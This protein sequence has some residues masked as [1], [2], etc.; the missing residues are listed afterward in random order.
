MLSYV[1]ST[2]DSASFLPRKGWETMKSEHLEDLLADGISRKFATYYLDLAMKEYDNPAYDPSYVKWA[3]EHGFLADCAYAYDLND[4][5]VEHYLSDYDYY[6]VWPVNNW[7]RVWINDKLTLK[8]VLDGT[9]FSEFMPRYY[10][11]TAPEG[12]RRL[13]DAPQAPKPATAEELCDV[14]RTVGEF[15]CKP[16]N[17]TTSLGFAHLAYHDGSYHIDDQSVDASSIERFLAEHPNYVFTEYLRPSRQFAP[18]SPHIHTLRIVTVNEN[19]MPRIVGGYLRI[20]NKFSGEANYIIIDKDNAEKFNVFID[21]NGETGA[22][23]P[24]KLTCVNRSVLTNEHPDNGLPLSGTIENY[25]ELKRIVMGIAQRF[26]TIEYMG[27]DIGV[28]DA[29]FKCMEINS[30]PGIKYMQIF[31]PI[32]DDPFLGD[33]FHRKVAA[34][35]GLDAEGKHARNGI[36][37]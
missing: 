30:H 24:G 2:S 18:Y 6:K 16:C 5:N 29:G 9:E 31:K 10:F 4:D 12:L 34:I 13:T 37:R 21:F 26:S 8:Q 32:Y 19:G 35:D 33:Y 7:T 11:Y 36:A 23:G 20:P 1:P 3:H 22:F 25:D 14:L 28:T 27:F 15:A 17:G